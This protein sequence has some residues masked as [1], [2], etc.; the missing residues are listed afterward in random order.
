MGQDAVIGK[1]S[2]QCL[3][4]GLLQ[5]K[6][7]AKFR[8][9][10]NAFSSRPDFSV[11]EGDQSELSAN[12]SQIFGHPVDLLHLISVDFPGNDAIPDRENNQH[13]RRPARGENKFRHGE[14]R[15]F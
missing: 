1:A 3:Q 4:H 10:W 12:G 14:E 6:T 9:F 13:K 5:V 2:P 8:D 7:V 15:I 11:L